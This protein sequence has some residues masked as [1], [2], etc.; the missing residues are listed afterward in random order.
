MLKLYQEMA[1]LKFSKFLKTL[2]WATLK[3]LGVILCVS[4]FAGEVFAQ[5]EVEPWGNITGIRHGGQ[6][7]GFES[8]LRVAEDGWLKIKS[9]SRERQSPNYKRIG[10]KQ[11]IETKIDSINFTE[12]VGEEKD[13]SANVDV[14]VSSKRI[15]KRD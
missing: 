12:T 13:G 11:I 7:I 4:V 8:S 3:C 6:L 15:L 5:A 10:N 2:P 14:K 9:T 1:K